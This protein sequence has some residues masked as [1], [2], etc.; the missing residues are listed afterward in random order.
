MLKPTKH[1]HPD[2]TVINASL[3]LLSHLK[4]KRIDDYEVL[5]NITKSKIIGGDFLFIPAL[6]FLFL[7]GLIE[8]HSKN[9]AIEYVG[10]K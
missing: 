10:K 2:R 9:D 5:R 4:K 6:N 7:L 8:Y 3:L 1:T